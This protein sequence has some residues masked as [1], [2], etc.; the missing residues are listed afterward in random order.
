LR[1]NIGLGALE[2]SVMVEMLE[3]AGRIGPKIHQQLQLILLGGD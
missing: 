2:P 1:A 3:L